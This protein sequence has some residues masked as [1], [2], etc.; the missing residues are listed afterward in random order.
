MD[1]PT[2]VVLPP[3]WDPILFIIIGSEKQNFNSIS[4]RK[5]K[6]VYKI[7]IQKHLTQNK[8]C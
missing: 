7:L 5:K 3:V 1:S 2:E 8:F 6:K 4:I